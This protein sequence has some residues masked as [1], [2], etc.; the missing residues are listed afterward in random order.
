MR[1]AL[2]LGSPA[3]RSRG[4]HAAPPSW[5]KRGRSAAEPAGAGRS[6][7]GS[8][9]LPV[10]LLALTAGPIGV[11]GLR[12]VDSA[13]PVT[14]AAVVPV[15]AAAELAPPPTRPAAEP[16]RAS[17]SRRTRQVATPPAPPKVVKPKKRPA[18][19]AV[20]PGCTG[21]RPDLSSFSN[22]ALPDRVLCTLPGPSGQQLRADAAVAFVSLARA[23]RSALGRDICVTDGYRTLPEQQVLRGRKPGL[24]ARPGTSEHGW[25]L[26]VDLACGVESSG[27]RQSAWLRRNATRYGWYHPQWAQPGG[28]K[29]EP[30]HWEYLAK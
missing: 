9:A 6:T 14:A 15:E 4:A 19:R 8:R 23:Y 29:P 25:G 12:G 18:P 13:Q 30:W 16:A 11:A 7:P 21:R 20:L 28:A 22:G 17:R 3:G 27:S 2:A 24:A 1:G 10:L 26:A 5:S